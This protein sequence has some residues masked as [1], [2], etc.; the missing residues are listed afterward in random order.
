MRNVPSCPWQ[1]RRRLVLEARARQHRSALNFPEEVLW[2][3]LSGGKLGVYFRR[4]VVLGGRYIADFFA[5]SVGLV[6]EVDG[7][8]HELKRKSDAWRDER[9][10]RS[11]YHVLRL[12]AE[13]VLRDLPQAVERVREEVSRREE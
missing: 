5:P 10:R 8:C 11:G 7:R 13:L 4:Q 12:G 9:L 2:H 1:R 6:V 3:E